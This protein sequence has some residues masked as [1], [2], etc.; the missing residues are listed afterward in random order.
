MAELV[1][2]PDSKSGHFGGVGSI[3]ST[4]TN[5]S[6]RIIKNISNAIKKNI[7]PKAYILNV[8]PNV[9]AEIPTMAGPNIAPTKA[10]LDIWEIVTGIG[11]WEFLTACRNTI[12][13]TL[14][15]NIPKTVIAI[16]IINIF[17]EKI[18]NTNIIE[19][20]IA[21]TGPTITSPSFA[22]SFEAKK[23]LIISPTLKKITIEPTKKIGAER[24]VT[25][26]KGYH[27]IIIPINAIINI[28]IDANMII[29]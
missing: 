11:F 8:K 22:I 23:L 2:A 12:G 15:I 7:T 17:W 21:K 26:H 1:D 6:L 27:W 14:E 13:M 20:I 16:K 5:L 25:S 4:P 19:P 24:S 10:M 18:L 29:L 28:L 3:P 9:S